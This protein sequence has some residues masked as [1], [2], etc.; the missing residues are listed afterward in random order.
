MGVWLDACRANLDERG[1]LPLADALYEALEARY[2]TTDIPEV[3]NA[4]KEEIPIR[5]L[6]DATLDENSRATLEDHVQFVE[7]LGM[8][9]YVRM[10]GRIELPQWWEGRSRVLV[11][12]IH[13]VKG[14]E[15]DTV[16]IL[17][18]SSKFDP[19]EDD[20]DLACADEVRLYYVGL[21]RAKR[22]AFFQWGER[23]K[24]WSAWPVR[25]YKGKQGGKYLEGNPGE[26]FLSFPA[27]DSEIQAYVERRVRVGEPLRLHQTRQGNYGFRHGGRIVGLFSRDTGLEIAQNLTG[28][29]VSL[30]VHSVYRYPVDEQNEEGFGTQ[31]IEPVRRQEWFYTVL[32]SGFVGG[33]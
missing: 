1:D 2:R 15:F 26:V 29:R 20:F 25:K 3:R 9:D 27:M 16:S 7:G 22:R 4:G 24:S 14:L 23:E 8:D 18:S 28:N 10:R 19:K 31:L 17:S 6:W 32:V 13:K 21:T 11:S 33:K 5:F 30:R 12:T